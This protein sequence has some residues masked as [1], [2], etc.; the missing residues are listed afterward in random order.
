MDLKNKLNEIFDLYLDATG[1]NP[2]D[3]SIR[4]GY[5][6]D[7]ACVNAASYLKEDP[8]GFLSAMSIRNAY[9]KVIEERSFTVEE[10]LD[11]TFEE[12]EE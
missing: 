5:E 7:S 12:K 10:L 2:T 8:T 3:G 4:L 1:K 9:R 11:G 6:S